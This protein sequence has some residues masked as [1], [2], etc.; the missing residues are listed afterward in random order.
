MTPT[1]NWED[2]DAIYPPAAEIAKAL[3]DEG[4]KV[5]S[6]SKKKG[7]QEFEMEFRELKKLAQTVFKNIKTH[8]PDCGLGKNDSRDCKV[9]TSAI[10]VRRK[11]VDVVNAPTC[12]HGIGS[13]GGKGQQVYTITTC[14]KRCGLDVAVKHYREMR[15][16]QMDKTSTNR[17]PDDGLRCALTMLLKEYRDPVG[18]FLSGKK[19]RTMMDQSKDPIDVLFETMYEDGFSNRFVQFERPD[20][21]WWEQLP[22]DEKENWDPNNPSIFEHSH[23]GVWLRQTWTVYVKPKYR[24]ALKKWNG[25][26]GGGGGNPAKFIDFV[27]NRC[28][29]WLVWVF[30]VDMRHNFL[31]ANN[32]GGMMPKHLVIEGGLEQESDGS[33]NG[34][35]DDGGS[36]SDDASHS[37]RRVA[38]SAKEENKRKK[39]KRENSAAQISLQNQLVALKEDRKEVTKIM[40]VALDVLKRIAPESSSG[41]GDGHGEDDNLAANMKAVDE[42]VEK[43]QSKAKDV[44]SPASMQLYEDYWKAKLKAN[45]APIKEAREK[46]KGLFSESDDRES[47][48]HERGD[49]SDSNSDSD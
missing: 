17:S 37:H 19:S 5:K 20:K 46:K 45:M 9:L 38:R 18:T 23:N 42:C 21:T 10:V 6:R 40:G 28:D 13:V 15:E 1:L 8:F 12:F 27:N 39:A 48:D 25:E 49:L 16:V 4:H 2:C 35:E 14:E 22:D 36:G 26:T 30:L 11:L 3:Q 43:L 32:A 34:D 33:L 44:M 31:L 41:G 7:A 24:L 47:D 29:K